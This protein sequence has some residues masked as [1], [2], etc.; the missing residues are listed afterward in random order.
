MNVQVFSDIHLEY[1]RD[2]S[3]N[4]IYNKSKKFNNQLLPNCDILILAGDI[5]ILTDDKYKEFLQYCSTN[6]KHVI[7][8]LGNHEFYCNDSVSNLIGRYRNLFL[9]FNNIHLLHDSYI[10]INGVIFYGFIGWTMPK[11]ELKEYIND[12]NKISTLDD[13]PWIQTITEMIQISKDKFTEF[14]SSVNS[15]VVVITHFPPISSGT[16]NPIYNGNFLN[17]YFTWNS[18]L[19]DNNIN[20]E[21]KIKCWI[22]G[23]THWSYDFII[24]NIR[25]ISNQ[26]GYYD[27]GINFNNGLVNLVIK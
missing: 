9:E 20:H 23:H 12:Y 15:N 1:F 4:T 18:Y 6:W 5:G 22:S 24:D 26:I 2:K 25:Y 13:K 14:L 8:V 10:E 21:N 16:S 7:Y 11:S 27:E 3:F 19:Q 17:W